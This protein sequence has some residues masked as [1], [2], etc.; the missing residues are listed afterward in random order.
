M[1]FFASI[2]KSV[3]FILQYIYRFNVF[4]EYGLAH[5]L[6]QEGLS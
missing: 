3:V 6:E 4:F 1:I 2:L 5:R